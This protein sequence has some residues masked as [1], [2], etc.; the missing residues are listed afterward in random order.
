MLLFPRV[1]LMFQIIKIN[2]TYKNFILSW[3]H[4]AAGATHHFLYLPL[5]RLLIWLLGQRPVAVLEEAAHFTSEV[6]STA[7][8]TA[9]LLPQTPLRSRLMDRLRAR[10]QVFDQVR[11]LMPLR[12]S[13]FL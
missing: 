9:P 10:P 13:L 7:R 6:A 11:R 1:L 12:W 5:R 4:A 2:N 3:M 8:S